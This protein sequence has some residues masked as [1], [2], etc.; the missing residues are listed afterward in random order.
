MRASTKQ[1]AILV[2]VMLLGFVCA[3]LGMSTILDNLW[4]GLSLYV[5]GL[6]LI[7]WVSIKTGR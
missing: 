6:A 5:V 7:V 1:F 3:I 4:L 2:I